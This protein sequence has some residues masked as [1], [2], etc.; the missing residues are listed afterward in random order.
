MGFAVRAKAREGGWGG[1]EIRLAEGS[2]D[3][4]GLEVIIITRKYY[5]RLNRVSCF[6]AFAKATHHF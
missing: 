6:G 2:F 1:G 3:S 5:R 4:R